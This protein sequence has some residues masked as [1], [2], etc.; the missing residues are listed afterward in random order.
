MWKYVFP[1]L[2]YFKPIWSFINSKLNMKAI[3]SMS[4]NNMEMQMWY[5]DANVQQT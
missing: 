2:A 1:S 3:Q 5:P 4:A